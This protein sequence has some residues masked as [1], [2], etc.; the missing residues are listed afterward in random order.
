MEDF[1]RGHNL[2]G[3]VAPRPLSKGAY[4]VT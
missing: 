3:G 1:P 4:R 2:A